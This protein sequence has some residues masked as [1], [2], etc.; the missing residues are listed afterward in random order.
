MISVCQIKGARGLLGWSASKLAEASGVG[1]A[2]VRR[3]ELQDGIPSSKT[4]TL[5][6][7]Q[8]T[9]EDAGIEFTGNPLVNPGVILNLKHDT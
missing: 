1:I 2:T 3:Y 6:S 4:S 5:L 9:L 7:I 8:T